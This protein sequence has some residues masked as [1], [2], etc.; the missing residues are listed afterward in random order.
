MARSKKGKLERNGVQIVALAL[1]EKK[2][3]KKQPVIAPPV[4]GPIGNFYT[5]KVVDFEAFKEF[6][7]KQFRPDASQ[8]TPETY[9]AALIQNATW[10]LTMYANIGANDQRYVHRHKAFFEQLNK[11]LQYGAMEDMSNIGPMH[12]P[13]AVT[14]R[15]YRDL[16][17]YFAWEQMLTPETHQKLKEAGTAL[18]RP[19]INGVGTEMIFQRARLPYMGVLWT[20]WKID[21]D[22]S[23]FLHLSP[24]DPLFVRFTPD[25]KSRERDLVVE[26]TITKYLRKYH[27]SLTD[28]QLQ[29][30]A[31]LHKLHC[32]DEGVQFFTSEEDIKRVYQNGPDSCMSKGDSAYKSPKHP[33][34]VYAGAPGVKLAA[35]KIGDGE[36]FSARCLVYEN[37]DNPN[38][39]RY[40]RVYGDTL[41]QRKLERK[42]YKHSSWKGLKVRKV[43]YVDK[44]GKP[45]P[46]TFVFPYID[47]V[48]G[49][50]GSAGSA[51]Y[52]V[53]KKDWDYWYID[54]SATC[55]KIRREAKPEEDAIY[56]CA[57]I[58]AGGFGPHTD[59]S[60]LRHNSYE[61][62]HQIGSGYKEPVQGKV[63]AWGEVRCFACNNIFDKEYTKPFITSEPKSDK[64][65]PDRF[66]C[67]RCEEARRVMYMDIEVDGEKVFIDPNFYVGIHKE[68]DLVQRRL[69][70]SPSEYKN[71]EFVLTY[72]LPKRGYVKLDYLAYRARNM[73]AK[74]EQAVE[75]SPGQWVLISD[76]V[77]TIFGEKWPK[78]YCNFLGQNSEGTLQYVKQGSELL[79]QEILKG[80]FSIVK[81]K[82]EYKASHS[83]NAKKRKEYFELI[84]EL[85][86]EEDGTPENVF[87]QA[88]NYDK[89][90]PLLD[91]MNTLYSYIEAERVIQGMGSSSWED[92]IVGLLNRLFPR[93]PFDFMYNAA[94]IFIGA[95]TD[96][97]AG[98]EG[99]PAIHI[100]MTTALVHGVL[101]DGDTEVDEKTGETFLSNKGFARLMPS[102]HCLSYIGQGT[103]ASF[104][105][106]RD[107][108]EQHARYR[109]AAKLKKA[110]PGRLEAPQAYP[111][112]YIRN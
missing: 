45:L 70:I 89:P 87:E 32:M 63:N 101:Q 112:Q 79:P 2:E 105:K 31:E 40:I 65:K 64:L 7:K 62:R 36:K 81:G 104:I 93:I 52:A 55:D 77:D 37:P 61:A 58:T 91:V 51:Q 102:R 16:M 94:S 78:Q 106:R 10:Q 35:L 67:I 17:R 18:Y 74:K 97:Y 26:T 20:K 82:L 49:G 43:P 66:F 68:R 72:A 80:R 69:D 6:V 110:K 8:Y 22:P 75:Y 108:E 12:P 53:T 50:N 109:A 34:A 73:F 56:I 4:Q 107:R 54:T 39:K 103:A 5:D 46:G 96:P 15:L 41:L 33:S 92:R 27:P 57:T 13:T 85:E 48:V 84:G 25:E 47:D 29:E 99:I 44:N 9:V 83:F 11:V 95:K 3:E 98:V 42:G 28:V 38:D 21:L 60:Y 71:Y 1:E 90:L 76:T 111:Y 59:Y 88:V 24:K 14:W 100:Q 30:I 86:E 23:H 19:T